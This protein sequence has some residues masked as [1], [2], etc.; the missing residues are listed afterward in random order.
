MLDDAAAPSATYVRGM[1]RLMR[2]VQ[3]LSLARELE[4]VQQIVRTT[5]RELAGSDGATFVLRDDEQCFYAD[6]D[7]IEPLWKG[8][9]FPLS[10]CISGWT[11]LNRQSAIIDDIYADDRIPHAAYRPTFVKSLAMVPIRSFDPIGA[12]G[13]YWA[14]DHLATE[15]EIKLLQALA[16]ATSIAMENVAVYSEL[17]RRVAER[18]ATLEKAN[19]EISRLSITDSLTGLLNRRGFFTAAGQQLSDA[20]EAGQECVVAFVDLDG[21]KGVNDLHGHLT[22][23]DMIVQVAETLRSVLREDDLLARLGGDEFC[24]F[25][26]QP[27]A[28]SVDFGDR[29]AARLA[30]RNADQQLAYLLAASMG[31][32]STSELTEPSLDDL[33]LLADER[34]YTSKRERGIARGAG[35]RPSGSASGR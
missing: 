29:L 30:D 12:I 1:E 32:A 27:V 25:L 23:D 34:M 16:D 13:N 8:S 10:A 19:A 24:A 11:M 2:A 15:E 35:A 28:R 22:G 20:L 33:L 14:E 4:Q 26:V 21:L 7:A 9:R 17:E 3:E 18:T 31:T 6:E 5:A